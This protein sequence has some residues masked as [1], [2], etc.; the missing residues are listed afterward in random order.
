MEI[1]GTMGGFMMERFRGPSQR[2]ERSDMSWTSFARAW[3]KIINIYQNG[4]RI[5][6]T[7]YADE[8]LKWQS[9]NENAQEQQS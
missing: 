7:S 3:L 5:R 4:I 8:Y 9:D 2:V 6:T 1:I